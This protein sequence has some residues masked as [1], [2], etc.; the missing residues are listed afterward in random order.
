MG[1]I[2][3]ASSLLAAAAA[4]PAQRQHVLGLIGEPPDV[5]NWPH[6]AAPDGNP[7]VRSTAPPALIKERD[8]IAALGKILFWDEQLSSDNTM[9]CG[10]CHPPRAG[11]TDERLGAVH[12]NGNFG[13][14]GVIRQSFNAFTG[15]VDYG[16]QV[17]PSLS[18]D[19]LVTG[20]H[21]P[22]MI[23][24]YVFERLFWD[25]RAGPDFKDPFG[26]TIPNFADWAACED[27]SV[28]PPISDV[29]MGHEGI[30]WTSGFIQ[31]KLATSFP[32][33][34]VDQTTIPP[35]AMALVVSGARY[36]RLF[37][38]VFFNHIQFGG[39]MGVTRERIACAIAHYMRTLIPDKAPVD[40]G[41]MTRAQLRGFQLMQPPR[42]NCFGCHSVSGN[43]TF[44]PGG[45]FLNPFDNPLSDGRFHGIG[46]PGQP[47][48]KTPTLRNVGLHKKFFSTGKGGTIFVGN[49][50]QLI[51]FY[52]AQPLGLGFNPP[53]TAAEEALVLD[54]L[55]NAL[56]DPRV[57]AEAAPFDRPQLASERPD[58]NPFEGNEY[59]NGT[60]GPSGATPEI[61][62]NSPA[63]V[64]KTGA[65]TWFKL[66][67][68]SA[69]PGANASLMFSGSPGPGPVIWIGSF[70]AVPAAPTNAEG[71]TTV[72]VPFPL[73]PA[74]V[75]V[76]VF[77]QWF[78]DDSGVPA[79]SDAAKL[80]PFQF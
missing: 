46:L 21:S 61:I 9:A 13:T 48:R 43:P 35:D 5:S 11:G 69:P 53:L 16:F 47:P 3:L 79:F 49:L 44:G 62:A 74:A 75:G 34:L 42:A 68:G 27:L 15:R 63:L 77:V 57:A 20:V 30:N 22:T 66:G 45:G 70:S 54:F 55:A 65:S 2:V 31:N 32:L 72:H 39:L 60:P 25:M 37:D 8:T 7:F 56:T 59:G 4:L 28:G 38:K 73:V 71:I 52:N 1:R 18:L 14:F 19:R 26:I 64:P 6:P 76:P 58:F 24:A 78:V 51:Q 40:L 36:D 50:T 67:V 23:G 12:P 33:A 17:N 80:T 10:T 29:E 41:T